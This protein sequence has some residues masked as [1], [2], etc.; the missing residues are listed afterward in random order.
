M[1]TMDTSVVHSRLWN[2]IKIMLREMRTKRCF[3][4]KGVLPLDKESTTPR[5]RTPPIDW[6]CVACEN[7]IRNDKEKNKQ[8]NDKDRYKNSHKDGK[9]Q[10][11]DES[12]DEVIRLLLRFRFDISVHIWICWKVC[13]G[14]LYWLVCQECCVVPVRIIN[15][16]FSIARFVRA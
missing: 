15:N 11:M 4:D 6:K 1:E 5:S 12:I 3:H 13:S 10:Q 14:M 2:L 8:T 7:R 16:P 9:G